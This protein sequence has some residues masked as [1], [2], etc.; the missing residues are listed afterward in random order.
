MHSGLSI[1]GITSLD[2]SYL[3]A[4]L[5]LSY[6]MAQ[7]ILSRLKMTWASW[8]KAGGMCVFHICDFQESHSISLCLTPL[9][10]HR[11]CSTDS[12]F[13]TWCWKHPFAY[14]SCT[15]L[16]A[17]RAQIMHLCQHSE[18]QV[19]STTLGNGRCTVNEGWSTKRLNHWSQWW[20][21]EL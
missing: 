16:W 9:L 5:H 11:S 3:V 14:V 4:S 20:P 10:W 21:Q 15:E 13:M 2:L 7:K 12:F 19:S 6:L 17:I 18:V 1:Q 8:E